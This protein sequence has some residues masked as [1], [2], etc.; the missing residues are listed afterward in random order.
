MGVEV[1][2]G[3]AT[4][5]ELGE[6]ARLFEGWE[7]VFSRFRRGSELNRVNGDSAPVLVVSKLFA[8][9]VRDA[10][11]AA[12]AT[13]GLVDPTLGLAIEAAG[14]DRDFSLVADD[15]ERPLGPTAPGRWRALRLSGRLLSRPARTRIDLNGVVKALVVDASLDLIRGEGFVA[16]GGDVAARGG[17]VVGLPRVG[18]LSLGSGGVATS[19]KTHRRWRRAGAWQHHLIDPR[20]G[21]PAESRWDEVTVAAASCLAAD[22]AAK[23]AFLLSHEGPN[24]LDQRGLPGRFVAGDEVVENRA[25]CEVL[26]ERE[27]AAA[28]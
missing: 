14:Y 1:V 21:R 8:S 11:G 22:V 24:W 28:A 23:A 15:E 16:A 2:V 17:A 5:H 26:G 7:R 27:P 10:L 9:V 12:S 18:S 25:W 20:T 19:G 4:E 6:I 13:D 3:G